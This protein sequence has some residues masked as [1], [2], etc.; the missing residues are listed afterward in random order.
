[1]DAESSIENMTA[2]IQHGKTN[3]PLILV[4]HSQE[5]HFITYE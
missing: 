5:I 4:S 1:M 2:I 3:E